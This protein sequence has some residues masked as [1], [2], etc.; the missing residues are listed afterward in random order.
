MAYWQPYGLLT[1]VKALSYV[2][3]KWR[4]YLEK[5]GRK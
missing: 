3:E 4:I 5:L 2:G 1:I